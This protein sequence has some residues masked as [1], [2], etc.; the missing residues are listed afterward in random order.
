MGSPAT[1]RRRRDRELW[2]QLNDSSGTGRG[3]T[4][5]L[6][7]TI[8][9]SNDLAVGYGCVSTTAAVNGLETIL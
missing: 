3:I 9:L 1:D 2:D 7:L 5:W 6:G 4:L 8:A